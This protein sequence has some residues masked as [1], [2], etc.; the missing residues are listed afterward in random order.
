MRK[1]NFLLCRMRRFERPVIRRYQQNL[2]FF[3]PHWRLIFHGASSLYIIL[4]DSVFIE[5]PCSEYRFMMLNWDVRAAILV[6]FWSLFKNFMVIVNLK[7]SS[8]T[9]EAVLEYI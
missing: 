4:I 8:S 1:S 3:I 9:V 6:G 5:T 7:L 2:S